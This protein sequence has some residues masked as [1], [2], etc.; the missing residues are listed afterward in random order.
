MLLN[1]QMSALRVV[2]SVFKCVTVGWFVINLPRKPVLGWCLEI[3]INL[4]LLK[5]ELKEGY[6]G[7]A[8]K[9]GPIFDA[10]V[11]RAYE[12]YLVGSYGVA[13][14]SC[15]Y[16]LDIDVVFME[17]CIGSIISFVVPDQFPSEGS[18]VWWLGIFGWFLISDHQKAV[19]DKLRISYGSIQVGSS[20]GLY[21]SF[22]PIFFHVE[23]PLAYCYALQFP[24]IFGWLSISFHQKE[25]LFSC[26]VSC[27]GGGGGGQREYSNFLR[28]YLLAGHSLLI[29]M[30]FNFQVSNIWVPQFSRESSSGLLHWQR[31]FNLLSFRFYLLRRHS[32]SYRYSTS[33]FL[34]S[35]QWL[36]LNQPSVE[37]SSS[38]MLGCLYFVSS[39]P[40]F[41]MDIVFGL[42]LQGK[43]RSYKINLI[44]LTAEIEVAIFVCARF[45]LLLELCIQLT[46]ASRMTGSCSQSYS[47]PEPVQDLIFLNSASSLP[48]QKMAEEVLQFN[49]ASAVE[50]VLQQHGKARDS[51]TTIIPPLEELKKLAICRCILLNIYIFIL[52]VNVNAAFRRYEV[53]EWVRK[54]VG[55]VLGKDLPAEPSEE[56]FRIGL[57]SGIILLNKIQPASVPKVVDAPVDTVI[58]P[59]GAALTAFQYFENVR[60]FLT[61]IQEMGIPTFEVPDL[62]QAG[63][64]GVW[65]F[66]GNP[67]PCITDDVSSADLSEMCASSSLQKLLCELLADQRAE[68]IPI[69]VE[70][71][72]GE[73]KEEFERRLEKQTKLHGLQ[74]K[75]VPTGEEKKDAYAEMG[76]ASQDES[77]STSCM[78]SEI[79]ATSN[80]RKPH[81]GAGKDFCNKA[82]GT[83]SSKHQ[84]LQHRTVEV[85]TKED[86]RLDK[87]RHARKQVVRLSSQ[88]SGYQKVL[89]ENRKLYNQVRDLKGSIR[90]YCRVRPFLPGQANGL[91]IL[92][93]IVDNS[94]TIQ[95]SAK[96]GNVKKIFTFNKAFGTN[97]TQEEVFADTQPLTGPKELTK[98]SLGVNYRAL[99]D[100]FEISEERKDTIDYN[101]SVQMME[102]YNEQVRDLLVTDGGNTRLEIRNN[103]SNGINVPNANLA[104]VT[105]TSD[106]IDLM[107]LGHKNRAVGSTSMNDRSSRSHSCLRVHVQGKD[108]T[109]GTTLR[110]C[111]HLVDLAGSERCDKTDAVGERLKEAQHI[112]RSLS[113]LGDVIAAVAQKKAH[114]PYR[115][116]KLTQLLKDSLGGQAKTLMFLGAA[117]S[118]KDTSAP[119]VKELKE[120]V[121]CSFCVSC[122][123]CAFPNVML[124]KIAMLK[125]ELA[126][127]EEAANNP[128]SPTSATKLARK[129]E[130]ANALHQHRDWHERKKLPTTRAPL[131]QHQNWHERTKLARKEEAANNPSSPTSTLKLARKEEAANNP[132]TPTSASKLARKEEAANNLGSPASSLCCKTEDQSNFCSR[133]SSL[134]S[135]DAWSTIQEAG[136]PWPHH[137]STELVNGCMSR[138]PIPQPSGRVRGHSPLN[139]SSRPTSTLVRRKTAGGK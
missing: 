50:D 78:S 73:V 8:V 83:L 135:Q 92:D 64:N 88:A 133:R 58:I 9:H 85:G 87:T 61:A 126:R 21:H 28:C 125:A 138:S 124:V 82:S 100:L 45:D 117:K 81:G 137:V 76:A 131:H 5:V 94:L 102:I 67:M 15:C 29:V 98:E 105:S 129:E 17:G 71:I 47:V 103:S 66:S 120:Q 49:V 34:V 80:I 32:C 40:F 13:I 56:D 123:C 62:E 114:V 25:V 44:L 46:Q 55:V 84:D 74:D 134:D 116:S 139:K 86:H 107:N 37:A 111:M 97:S 59:D 2:R 60:N 12:G 16:L 115:N 22:T 41:N 36:V 42:T 93:E 106:V 77:D 122:C 48:K 112:N 26:L 69:I 43:I 90:V 57:R 52:D 31:E 75:V 121:F 51:P 1:F 63:A 7:L 6:L 24:E 68:E 136:S 119:E 33:H 72:I 53:A 4:V 30:Y 96:H 109:S 27:G 101:I 10:G 95:T 127:K 54:M 128:S 108:L 79:E 35:E 113:A 130:A 14:W 18:L 110:G 65:K 38:L 132:G 89:E 70:N 118:N 91:N 11:D 39:V 20:E 104:N 19:L 23:L 3:Q 99:S